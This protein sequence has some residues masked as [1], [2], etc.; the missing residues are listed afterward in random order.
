MEGWCP[1]LV[2]IES[3]CNVFTSIVAAIPV[4]GTF[5]A[6]IKAG[7][8]NTERECANQHPGRVING[9]RHRTVRG[10]LIG[11]PG[12]GVE[13]IRVVLQQLILR[14]STEVRLRPRL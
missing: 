5:A 14:Q 10:E 7:R 12:F 2:K 13:R 11:N 9:Y 3:A 8:L 1:Q 4:S 6:I